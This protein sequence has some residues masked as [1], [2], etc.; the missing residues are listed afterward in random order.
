MV[1]FKNAI[2]AGTIAMTGL[3]LMFAPAKAQRVEIE[4]WQYFFDGR[5][6][7]INALIEKFEAENPDIKVVHRHFPYDQYRTKVAAAVPAGE[8]PDVVQLYYGWLGEY[9]KAGL[10]QPLSQ[11][12]FNPDT[13][14]QEFFPM[15]QEMKT[16]GQY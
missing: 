3:L 5:V 11:E 9:Q 4:Y 13:I 7:A 15:V 14:D 8:G 16:D 12:R 2:K 1:K 6:K 10:L